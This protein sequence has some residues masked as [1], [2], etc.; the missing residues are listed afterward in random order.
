MIRIYLYILYVLSHLVLQSSVRT[1]HSEL[2]R[3][4][5]FGKRQIYIPA[6]LPCSRIVISVLFCTSQI[7]DV[8]PWIVW[9]MG[10]NY[11]NISRLIYGRKNPYS[12]NIKVTFA[13]GGST[14]CP[15]SCK[16]N[17]YSP[18]LGLN[19]TKTT[20]ILDGIES[21]LFNTGIPRLAKLMGSKAWNSR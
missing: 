20:T 6:C 13:F 15:P 18:L 11:S 10:R 12:L 21:N 3:G 16:M 8:A 7:R 14:V 1:T 4:R 2:Y 17:V 19:R 5:I 9:V